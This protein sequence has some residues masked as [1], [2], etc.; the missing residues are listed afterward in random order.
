MVQN[1]VNTAVERLRQEL[2]MQ[3]PKSSNAGRERN[4]DGDVRGWLFK[5]E[6]FFKVDNIAE[7]CK[8]NE[9][10]LSVRMFKPKSLTEVYGLCKLEEA[11]PYRHPPTHKDVIEIMM[12]ELL[13][14]GVIRDSQSP[15]SSSVVMVKKKDG[16]WRMCIDY[17]RL[18]NANIKNNFPILVIEKLIDE[19]KGSQ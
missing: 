18:N 14:T 16:T 1:L 15:F 9:I 8:R 19:L 10:E 11:R 13:D 2:V 6:Q 4:L 7:D 12:K 3:R 17:K 5:C